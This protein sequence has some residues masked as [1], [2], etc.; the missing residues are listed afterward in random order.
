MKRNEITLTN[1]QTQNDAGCSGGRQI[2]EA[3][4]RLEQVVLDGLQRG[5][6]R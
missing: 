3:L 5:R 2:R 6:F 1:E 4:T